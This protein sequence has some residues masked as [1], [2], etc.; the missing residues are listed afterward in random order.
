MYRLRLP[1]GV[2]RERVVGING[3]AAAGGS[4]ETEQIHVVNALEDTVADHVTNLAR[5]FIG[6]C[7]I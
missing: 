2:E 3:T 6:L 1:Q 7:H 5:P 4:V